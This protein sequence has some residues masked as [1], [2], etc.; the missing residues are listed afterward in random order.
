MM[1]GQ[2]ENSSYI[3]KTYF[4]FCFL[5]QAKIVI[6]EMKVQSWKPSTDVKLGLLT[7]E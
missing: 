5:K 3:T 6:D 4:F 7:L 1:V 2:V